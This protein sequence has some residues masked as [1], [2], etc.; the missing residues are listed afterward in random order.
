MTQLAIMKGVTSYKSR[1]SLLKNKNGH[2]DSF[3]F[4]YTHE[5][6]CHF[7]F[8]FLSDYSANILRVEVCTPKCQYSQIQPHKGLKRKENLKL[9]LVNMQYTCD[10]KQQTC[11]SLRFNYISYFQKRIKQIKKSKPLQAYYSGMMISRAI[12]CQ[13]QASYYW[14]V[15]P[16]SDVHGEFLGMPFS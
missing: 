15:S 8:S 7:I 10:H 12:S 14:C 13:L 16:P 2:V 6:P 1:V 9:H 3:S 4:E 11:T 5:R